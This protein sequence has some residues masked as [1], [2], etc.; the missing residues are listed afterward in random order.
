MTD[1]ETTDLQ[2]NAS[3][4][5]GRRQEDEPGAAGRP[6]P[7]SGHDDG[8]TD[9]V[10]EGPPVEKVDGVPGANPGRRSANRDT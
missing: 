6:T 1:H 5:T 2:D 7:G 3:A 8:K 4:R 9:T 10:D